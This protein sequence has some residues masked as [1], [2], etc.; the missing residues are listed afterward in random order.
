MAKK[1]TSVSRQQE[2]RKRVLMALGYYDHQLHRGIASFAREAGWILDT[3]MAHYGVIPDYW[4]GDG[5]ITLLL[6]SREDLTGYIKSQKAA[7]VSL[8]MDQEAVS[9]S[10]V[11][12]DNEQIGRLGAMHLLERGFENLAFYKY[13][14]IEDVQ[15]RERGFRQA[16]EAA[17]ARYIPLDWHAASAREVPSASCFEWLKFRLKELLLPAGI[18][19]QS[20]NRAA[21]LISASEAVGLAIPEQIALVGVDNDV[22]SC[23]FA[24]VPISS[25]DSQRERLAYEGSLLLD[26]LMHGMRRPKRPVTIAPEGVVVRKSSDILAV[27]HPAVARALGFIWEHFQEPISVDDVIQSS[28]ISR[29]GI[30]R[31]FEKHVGRSI[32]EELSRKRVEHAKK[33]MLESN[34]KLHRIA[35]AS[36][37][38]GGE[39]FSRAFTRIVG[40]TP[41]DY[42]TNTSRS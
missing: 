40:V 13:S 27:G 18:M 38:S 36:G 11:H 26:K 1:R 2:T 10:R 42:R 4:Q 28:R 22:Y 7:V 6:P 31:A 12:L 29:C 14:N 34:A 17:G 39:H 15:G 21:Y 37:F 33:L 30:Y 16:A 23:E 32:G 25:V 8:S 3:T 35:C 5:I 20:D 24:P 41:S 9:V 19:A